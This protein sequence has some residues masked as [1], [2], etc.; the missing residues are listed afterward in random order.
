MRWLVAIALFAC[1]GCRTRPLELDDGG[2]AGDLAGPLDGSG[3]DLATDCRTHSRDFVTLDKLVAVDGDARLG[4]A[5]RVRADVVLREGCDQLAD[6]DTRI[7]IGNATDFAVITARAWRGSGPCGPARTVSRVIVISDFGG[8]LSNARIVVQ[9]GAPGGTANLTINVNPMMSGSCAGPAPAVCT[10]D[11]HCP[12]VDFRAS[13]CLPG[14]SGL[15]CFVSCAS[16]VD[17]PPTLPYCAPNDLLGGPA[18][19]CLGTR[20]ASS[21]GCPVEQSCQP[22]RCVALPAAGEHACTCGRDCAASQLCATKLDENMQPT[23][24]LC[25]TP[26]TTGADCPRGL[27]ACALGRCRPLE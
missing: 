13:R 10:L 4:R 23:A 15:G 27:E 24:P 6:V 21:C 16:D 20:L 19:V 11:C 22:D 7:M 9:D 2:A 8:P 1:G 3:G 12:M 17:C 14:P 5:I 18:F 26:C 25:I